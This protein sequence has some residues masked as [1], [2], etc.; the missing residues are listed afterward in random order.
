VE[1]NRIHHRKCSQSFSNNHAF[2][3]NRQ[4]D[5]EILYLL[6]YMGPCIV[7]IFQYMSNK[8]QYYTVY[9]I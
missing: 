1:F 3:E 6:T 7:R 9:F 4:N 5:T 2:R 8:M